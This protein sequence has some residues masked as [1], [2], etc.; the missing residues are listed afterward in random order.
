MDVLIKQ[1][2]QRRVKVGDMRPGEYGVIMEY[3]Y[4]GNVVYRVPTSHMFYVVDLSRNSMDGGWHD[5]KAGTGPSVEI[6][7]GGAVLEITI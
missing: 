6:L 1:L 3:P 7:F 2:K 5:I 4:H